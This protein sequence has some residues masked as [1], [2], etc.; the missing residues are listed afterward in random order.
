M[1]VAEELVKTMSAGN[2]EVA[3][4]IIHMSALI[5]VCPAHGSQED[6]WR[7]A[8]ELPEEGPLAPDTITYSTILHAIREFAERDIETMTSIE[9][10]TTRKNM[11]ILE[12][13]RLWTDVLHRWTHDGFVM[14]NA[15]VQ[16]FASVLLEGTVD[17]DYYDVLALYNQTMGIPIKMKEP[18]QRA[19]TSNWMK[20]EMK[21]MIETKKGTGEEEDVPFVYERNLNL[22]GEKKPWNDA[23]LEDQPLEE[24]EDF[25]S[26]FN[27]IKSGNDGP[28]LLRPESRDLTMI[29]HA[30]L[31][32]TQGA[33]AG[34]AYWE[35]LTSGP[36]E[37]LVVPNKFATTQYLRLLRLSRASKR[38]LEVL[39]AQKGNLAEESGTAF[40]I[41]ISCCSRD[42]KNWSTFVH[43]N[44]MMNLMEESLVLPDQRVVEAYIA[45][46][47]DL[48]QQPGLLI[49]IKGLGVEFE[50]DKLHT[51][52]QTLGKKLVV[53]LQLRA[54][55]TLRPHIVRAD[56]AFQR[57]TPKPVGRRSASAPTEWIA[58]DK[59]VKNMARV[60]HMVGDVL[61]TENA[62]FIS[63]ED[64]KVIEADSVLLGRYSDRD[65]LKSSRKKVYPTK[66][67]RKRFHLDNEHLSTQENVDT[68]ENKRADLPTDARKTNETNIPAK[69]QQPKTEDTKEVQLDA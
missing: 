37:P 52:M 21:R 57:G 2:S 19:Q 32:I 67:H 34:I 3:P 55:E 16:A 62:I 69:S 50:K 8:G 25:D 39:R 7:I 63:K 59:I 22:Q 47:N 9:N 48:S 66:E 68:E 11:M 31:S 51:N 27:P 54:L 17:H 43:A 33:A 28:Q 12:A 61:K 53:N 41:G 64:R 18:P 13:K 46:I 30:C 24:D 4:N 35:D 23:H 14:D 40:R 29:E 38:S 58:G 26:L 6:M 36:G 56:E 1:Q 42:K 65:I 15:L 60:G 45:F 5:S 20:N 49:H 10:I 44:E